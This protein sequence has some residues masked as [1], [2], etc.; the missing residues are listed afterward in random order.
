MT[1]NRQTF[2]LSMGL[3]DYSYMFPYR[4]DCTLSR[5]KIGNLSLSTHVRSVDEGLSYASITHLDSNLADCP[6]PNIVYHWVRLLTVVSIPSFQGRM[7]VRTLRS[8]P[9]L[10]TCCR[11]KRLENKTFHFL[12]YGHELPTIPTLEESCL[13]QN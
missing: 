5:F 10:E 6:I 3:D 2:L 13:I 8:F 1:V 12:F 4:S 11:K 9:N 7:V